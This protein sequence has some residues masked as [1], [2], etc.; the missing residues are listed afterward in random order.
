M[1]EIKLIRAIRHNS[2]RIDNLA[3]MLNSLW[4]SSFLSDDQ[5][6]DNE[7]KCLQRLDEKARAEIHLKRHSQSVH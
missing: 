5:R 6:Q 4:L 1:E 3:R 7:E 2:Y